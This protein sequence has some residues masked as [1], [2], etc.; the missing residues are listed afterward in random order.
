MPYAS[1]A[2]QRFFHTDTARKKG[3]TSAIVSEFDKATKGK[4]IPERKGKTRKQKS[5]AKLGRGMAG[6]SR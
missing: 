6:K 2:Q 4:S 5:I 3:I 1:K